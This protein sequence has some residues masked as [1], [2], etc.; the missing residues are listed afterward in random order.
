MR[1]A[2]YLP[3]SFFLPSFA[4]HS[5]GCVYV[6]GS[7]EAGA[8]T[9]PGS[10][11]PQFGGAVD[12]YLLR[13]APDGSHPLFATYLG[14]SEVDRS[15]GLVLDG[16][17]NAGL[18]VHTTREDFSSAEPSSG[19]FA[20]IASE[21]ARMVS[22]LPF[23][24]EP[25]AFPYLIRASAGQIVLFSTVLSPVL[26]TS[27][28]APL[29]ASCA[30][31]AL[32]HAYLTVWGSDGVQ[33]LATYLPRPV[34]SNRSIAVDPSGLLYLGRGADVDRVDFNGPNEPAVRCTTGAASRRNFSAVSPGEII[35]LLGADMGPQEGVGADPSGTG[36]YP[37]ALAGV[38]VLVD[39]AA[40]PL[41]YVQASQINA[42]VPY[43]VSSEGKVPIEVEYDGRRLHLEVR[44]VPAGVGLF[45]IDGSGI[46]QAAALNQD[47]TLNSELNPATKSS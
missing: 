36:R 13:L 29:R 40:A 16:Q 18:L 1:Y 32:D 19:V 46:G 28:N 38:R 41:L 44:V 39:G 14:G 15:N 10:L 37:Q 12:A 27:R 22:S 33:V 34:E 7:E 35:T 43:A 30:D 47:G 17:G 45:A 25:S 2:T 4:I 23:T 11:Q 31:R 3:D 5:D 42:V 6:A 8:F 24:V 20:W 9:T 26:P 21:G